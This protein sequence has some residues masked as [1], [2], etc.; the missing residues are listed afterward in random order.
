M[1]TFKTEERFSD[2]KKIIIGGNFNPINE[3][4][5]N[6]IR[7]NIKRKYCQEHN[8]KLVEISYFDKDKINIILSELLL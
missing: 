7:D 6:Q 1:G 5:S 3:F 8:I 2:Y 4:S